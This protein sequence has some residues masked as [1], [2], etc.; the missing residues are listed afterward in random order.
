MTHDPYTY[1]N[2]SLKVSRFKREWKQTDRQTERETD[3]H[4]DGRKLPINLSFQV[5]RLVIWEETG[6]KQ[7][8]VLTT[9]T[10][11]I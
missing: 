4:T 8:L 11:V 9:T 1:K 3:G 2:S 5:T 6:K 10:P 7:M